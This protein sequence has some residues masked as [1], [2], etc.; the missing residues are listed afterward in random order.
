MQTRSSVT[1]REPEESPLYLI[2]CLLVGMLKKMGVSDWRK[3]AKDRDAWI[4][5]LKYVMVPYGGGG[6][7]RIS[8]KDEFGVVYT[9]FAFSS[10]LG[11]LFS[12]I[13]RFAFILK[14]KENAYVMGRSYLVSKIL[15]P[16]F[17]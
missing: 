6:G 11:R 17:V 9:P 8:R 3:I 10:T 16:Y 1:S 13:F 14:R 4:L 12:Q 2:L 15:S 5:I 7:E